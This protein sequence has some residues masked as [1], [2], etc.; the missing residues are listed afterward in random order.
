MAHND[1]FPIYVTRK[2]SDGVIGTV[3]VGVAWLLGCL[4]LSQIA[5]LLWL[6]VAI[7]SAVQVV[8]GWF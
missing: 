5:V 2:S 8:V 3:S 4:L 7:V 6:I 1:A